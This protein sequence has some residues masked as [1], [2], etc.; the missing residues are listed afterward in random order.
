MFSG[1]PLRSVAV[2]YAYIYISLALSLPFLLA[3]QTGTMPLCQASLPAG[4]HIFSALK[5]APTVQRFLEAPPR[6]SASV[7][8]IVSADA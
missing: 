6:R 4:L 5:H 3:L 8:L 2:L 1:L 7:N